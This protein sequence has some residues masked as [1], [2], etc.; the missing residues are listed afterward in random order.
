M[1]PSSVRLRAIAVLLVAGSALTA[2]R[3][4]QPPAAIVDG[5]RVTDQQVAL[6]ATLFAFLGSLQRSPCGTPA[7]GETQASACA[8]FTLSRVIQEDLVKHY[9]AE[10]DITVAPSTV[11]QAI[12]QL[13][14]SLGGSDALTGQLKAQGLTPADF[15]A[16]ARRLLLFN[17]V[18]RALATAQLSDAALHAAYDQQQA[19]FTQI[20]AKHILV[21]TQAEADRIEAK[22]TPSNFAQLAQRFSTDTTSAAN[23]GD[24]GTV[25]AAT[26]DQTIVSAA[27][28]LQPGEISRPVQTQSGW[29]IIQLVS[30]TVSPF[31]Q[32][33][34]QLIDQQSQPIFSTWLLGE[35]SSADITVNPKYGRL[36]P[37]TGDVVPIRS[38]ATGQSS[39]PSASSGISPTP[40]PATTPSPSP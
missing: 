29:H 20:H 12:A 4:A 36:D 37:T 31:E 34:S 24:L 40:G 10:H 35:L 21:A 5:E 13:E 9:A 30:A 8:R 25:S 16:L 33:R 22:V 11:T 7:A 23:G 32:V 39:S 17:E 14:N 1:T 15:T 27:L 3:A 6:D 2:C 19:S 28:A 38:T 26:L 18:R